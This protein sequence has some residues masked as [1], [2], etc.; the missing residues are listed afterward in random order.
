[1]AGLIGARPKGERDVEFVIPSRIPLFEP[2]GTPIELPAARLSAGPSLPYIGVDPFCEIVPISTSFDP[3][4]EQ[5]IL[6]LLYAWLIRADIIVLARD[7]PDPL[8]S[9]ITGRRTPEG[10]VLPVEREDLLRAYPCAL[11]EH[12]LEL[13]DALHDLVLEISRTVPVVCA[14]GNGY[15][16][17]MIYP[18]SLA[19]A[20]VSEAEARKGKGNGIIAV[21]A[22]AATRQRAAYSTTS[23]Q[24]G[25]ISIYA[26]SGDGER[27]D[28]G[29]Q[30]RDTLDPD[31]RPYD[32][33]DSYVKKLNVE[34]TGASTTPHVIDAST[35]STQPVISTDVPG[36]AGYNSSPFP[37]PTNPHGAI[38]D[39][40]SYYCDFSGTSAACAITAGMLSLA[41]SAG[42]IA[43]GNGS[44]AK[45]LLRG[46]TAPV[47][48]TAGTPELRW[49]AL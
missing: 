32:Q 2:D 48:D 23:T 10:H 47:D 19:A 37:Y 13:W 17:S 16:N 24:S 34:Y 6:T 15:D 38:F 3:D 1:M 42:K 30:R 49:S 11:T 12:E 18:A 29:M 28:I 14:A 40:R 21:G 39:Y 5:L 7:F 4:P 25:Q 43:K 31:Y 45:T 22:R 41:Y 27:L 9:A 33:A 8:R 44:L 26:P 35:Y 46:G 20:P 36:A